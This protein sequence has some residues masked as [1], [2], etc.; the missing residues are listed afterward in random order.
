MKISL[1]L[2]SL[3]YPGY[4]VNDV[5]QILHRL[6]V[7]REWG[8]LSSNM[9]YSINN[10]NPAKLHKGQRYLSSIPPTGRVWHKAFLRWVWAQ[11]R[12]ADA[13]GIPKNASKKGHL[14]CQ[15]INL[16]PPRRVKA[17][18]DAPL[19]LEVRPEN[20]THLTRS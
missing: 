18:G 14:R 16:T 3:L 20:G 10:V 6:L 9:T 2:E 12:S 1:I 17:Q 8:K 7:S 19:K 5:P 15:A 4:T 11:G 13:L